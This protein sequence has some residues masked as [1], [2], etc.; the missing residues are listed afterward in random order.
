MIILI[1]LR[2]LLSQFINLEVYDKITYSFYY[3][4]KRYETDS[5]DASWLTKSSKGELKLKLVVIIL[6]SKG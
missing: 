3:N 1:Y 6:L 5:I 4:G 2:K